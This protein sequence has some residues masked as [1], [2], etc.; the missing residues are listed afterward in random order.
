MKKQLKLNIKSENKISFSIKSNFFYYDVSL[1]KRDV[2]IDIL[3]PEDINQN[4]ISY[5]NKLQ[6]FLDA[7]N[8]NKETNKIEKL[9]KEAISL[10][11]KKK[12]FNLLIFL[13]LQIYE[14]NNL[15]SKLLDTFKD[16][17]VLENIK[18]DKSLFKYLEKFNQIFCNVDIKT[19]GYDPNELY[20]I[21]LCYLYFYDLDNKY[22]SS[23]INLLHKEN[24][25]VLYNILIK[26]QSYF[27][28][29][30][31]QDLEF[32]NKF[33]GYSIQNKD[34][35]T[36]E[37]V[38]KYIKDIETYLNVI[39]T[40]K[41]DFIDYFEKPIK[42]KSELK[43]VKKKFII[44][45]KEVNEI[46]NIIELIKKIISFS[47]NHKKLLIYLTNHFWSYLLNQYKIADRF[48]INNCYKLRKLFKEYYK[49]ILNLYK[50]IDKEKEEDKY[51]IRKDIKSYYD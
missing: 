11:K 27:L 23:N 25:E 36:T 42:I 37:K 4:A 10:Y 44:D 18:I 5:Y 7:L 19:N 21:I 26:F 31:N 51:K 29:P 30:L 35:K 43:L 12:D 34:L 17:K 2:Y 28:K 1:Q 13:F 20:G 24:P 3:P 8:K 38:L 49:L 46:D 50:E 45:K 40:Y 41:D 33:I 16:I 47:E 39:N 15:C 6:I 48:N 32:N 14:N 9:Y 22:F